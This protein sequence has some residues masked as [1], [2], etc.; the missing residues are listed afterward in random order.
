MI[1]FERI[2]GFDWDR[3]NDRKSADKQGVSRS[4]AEQVFFKDP[5]LLVEDT[6]HSQLERR[7]HALGK[8]NFGRFLH[9]T[10]TLRDG[11]TKIRVISA[12][13]IHRKEKARYEQE[14]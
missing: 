14:A 12:R 11:E 2:V 5:L 10:F 4:E 1:D 6:K 3:S 13:D 7:I 8:T 9:V